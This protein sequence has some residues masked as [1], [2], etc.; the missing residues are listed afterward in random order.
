MNRTKEVDLTFNTRVSP[1]NAWSQFTRPFGDS[2]YT[3]WTIDVKG[4]ISEPVIERRSLHA[5][6]ETLE[7]LFPGIADPL[8]TSRPLAT[9]LGK[10]RDRLTK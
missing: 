9:R 4:P 2:Q 10:L 1:Q 7:R 6:N 3:L 5:V 8:P